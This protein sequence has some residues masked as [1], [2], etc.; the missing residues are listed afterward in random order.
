MHALLPTR[1]LLARTASLGTLRLIAA[2]IA[3]TAVAYV[4]SWQILFNGLPHG[5][6]LFHLH[7][8]NFAASTFPGLPTWWY[9]WDGNGLPYREGY[10]LT[11]HWLAVAAARMGGTNL[12]GG[13]Q[14]VDFLVSPICAIGVYVF[15]DW[16]L[17]RPLAG[18]IAGVL[19]LLSPMSWFGLYSLGV[20]TDQVSTMLFM[21]AMIAL[22]M[23]ATAWVAGHR[24]WDFRVA[25]VAFAILSS[26]VG[27]IGPAQ[28]PGA[29]GA[30]LF[31]ALVVPA[32]LRKRWLLVVTPALWVAAFSLAAFWFL[33]IRDYLG[34]TVVRT[35]ALVFNSANLSLL[36]LDVV[37]QLH[38]LAPDFGDRFS[39]TPAASIPAL[40]GALAAIWERRARVFVALLALALVFGTQQWALAPLGAVPFAQQFTG[41]V[42]RPAV[43]Y[44][45]F[46]VPILAGLGLVVV[47]Q[48]VFGWV[49]DVL[50]LRH[51]VLVP[52]VVGAA[53]RGSAFAAVTAL[54]IGFAGY[55]DRNPGHLSYGPEQ[56][57]IGDIWQ[58]SPC[59]P[60]PACGF[61]DS[62][63]ADQLLSLDRWRSPQ[64]GC[65]FTKC[66]EF[67]RT[68]A[69]L[70]AVFSQAPQRSGVNSDNYLLGMAFHEISGGASDYT[71]AGQLVTSEALNSW[72][73]DNTLHQRGTVAKAQ[74]AQV[75]GLDSIVLAGPSQLGQGKDY[76]A[77][78]WQRTAGSA[79]VDVYANPSPTGLAV[80][81][82]SGTNVLVVGASQASTADVYNNMFKYATGG[83]IPYSQGWLVRSRSSFVDDYSIAELSRYRAL[84]LLGYR[85]HDHD[86][87][88]NL[89]DQYAQSGGAVF[90]ETGWQFVDPDW[91]TTTVPAALPVSN[92]HWGAL[93]PRAAVAVYGNP[94][95]GWGS[96]AYQSTGWGEQRIFGALGRASPGQRRRPRRSRGLAAREGAGCVERD[97]LAGPRRKC[98]LDIRGRFCHR[99]VRLSVAIWQ[100]SD[101]CSSRM[102][103]Q[104]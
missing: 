93:D 28:W 47:P 84:V 44:L 49:V 81:W 8:T 40:F 79:I 72:V 98:A 33:P 16:R 104:R 11:A 78:G 34:F 26:G 82:P 15:C 101:R 4:L 22:D 67:E 63:L 18:L 75:L 57:R 43:L 102:A 61:R 24:G 45:Q 103:W 59:D 94:D 54:I 36:H 41:V 100:Q 39:L 83:L 27:L 95:S 87:A 90:I 38:P 70:A 88:W 46:L 7:L 64:V 91:D 30:V 97:E 48:V 12:A 25:V 85:Y 62:P 52:V 66:A 2:A 37:L 99:G 55:V 51:R 5:D 92:L 68:Q 3:L 86:A 50:G 77:L 73:V 17:K 35:P 13:I 29:V 74:L 69:A 89:I 1:P 60:G 20:Y 10:P 53:T 23:V 58:R 21:P 31:Y 71:Y 96:M 9:P 32:G 19:Y 14:I 42:H 56:A 76:R 80:Q 6:T 65:F